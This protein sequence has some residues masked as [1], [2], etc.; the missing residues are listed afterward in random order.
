[1]FCLVVVSVSAQVGEDESWVKSWIHG[2]GEFLHHDYQR[3]SKEDIT[4][5]QAGYERI[6]EDNSRTQEDEWAGSYTIDYPDPDL[7]STSLDEFRWSPRSGF[8]E[9]YVYTCLPELRRLSY[10]SVVASASDVRLLPDYASK[11]PGGYE[12]ATRYL[13]VKWGERH[14]LIP[15]DKLTIFSDRAAGLETRKDESGIIVYDFYIKTDELE[16]PV[17][18]LPVLP[19]GY[20]RFVKKPIDARITAVAASYRKIDLENEWWDELIIPVTINVGSAHG[21]KRKMIFR[22]VG[23]DE[24]EHIEIKS[25]GLRSS[26]GAI[27]RSIRKNPCVKIDETDDCKNHDYV[28]VKAGLEV[29]TSPLR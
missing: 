4:K 1:M 19:P 8:V 22:A 16:K 26:Q 6:G 12:P 9:V 23:V 24:L 14:Y 28:S 15:E 18:G 25:A 21:V 20:E 11:S 10:G 3:Y 29:T 27:V 7:G 2:T 17:A 13:K 5:A